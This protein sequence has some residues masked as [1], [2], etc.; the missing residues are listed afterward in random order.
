MATQDVKKKLSESEIVKLNQN[1]ARETAKLPDKV[2]KDEGV[3]FSIDEER[4]VL[5]YDHSCNNYGEKD[6]DIKQTIENMLDLAEFTRFPV[7][8]KFGNI[9]FRL[10][11]GMTVED[12]FN[13]LNELPMQSSV[14]KFPKKK[15]SASEIVEISQKKAGRI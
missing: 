5:L 4:N 13:I 3:Y 7:E 6:R 15:L 9:P 14:Q 12:A 1:R 11:Y 2:K 8:T 10:E